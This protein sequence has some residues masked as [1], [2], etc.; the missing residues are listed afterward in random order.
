MKGWRAAFDLNC[1]AWN[2]FS[3]Y[4]EKT[5]RGLSAKKSPTLKN[6][7]KKL[8]VSQYKNKGVWGVTFCLQKSFF[9]GVL[10]SCL[11][12]VGVRFTTS[13][14]H[15]GQDMCRFQMTSAN[16]RSL[17]THW[18]VPFIIY[19][20][21]QRSPKCSSISTVL[22]LLRFV[23]FFLLSLSVPK[24]TSVNYRNICSPATSI[25]VF[26]FLHKLFQLTCVLFLLLCVSA[27]VVCLDRS[28][29]LFHQLCKLQKLRRH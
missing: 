25:Q 3:I 27:E 23:P 15:A 9:L 22:S 19:A 16:T 29:L 13:S 24:Q 14:L 12:I 28:L 11:G 1:C 26:L 20:L 4:L 21:V 6:T 18:S 5:R 17:C 10:S 8:N 2:N 7:L